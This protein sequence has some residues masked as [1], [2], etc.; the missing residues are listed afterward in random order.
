MGNNDES[1]KGLNPDKI[2]RQ[3]MKR[4]EKVDVSTKIEPIVLIEKGLN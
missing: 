1:G 2:W 3:N 4:E